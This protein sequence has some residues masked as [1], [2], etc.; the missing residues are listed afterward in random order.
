MSLSK[1][2][3][4]L[5]VSSSLSTAG[6]TI[7]HKGEEV[8]R[9]RIHAIRVVRDDRDISDVVGQMFCRIRN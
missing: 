5:K 4:E 9:I 7:G 2:L 1:L 8:L 6:G 3:K